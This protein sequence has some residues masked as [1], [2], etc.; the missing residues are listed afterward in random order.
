MTTKA[1][2]LKALKRRFDAAHADGMESLEQGDL[3]AFSDAIEREKQVIAE[4]ADEV[5]D[6]SS[7]SE[8]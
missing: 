1:Q 7:E 2:R 3:D 8:K 5:A 6:Q 4:Q